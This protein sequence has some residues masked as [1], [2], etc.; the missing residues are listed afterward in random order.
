D[1]LGDFDVQQ[2]AG[3]HDDAIMRNTMGLRHSL[4]ILVETAVTTNPTNSDEAL[5]PTGPA[6]N[7]RRVASHVTV[8]GCSLE[9]MR[10]R[11][12]EVMNVTGMAPLRKQ[13]EGL[14]QNV[15][16]YFSGQ[17]EGAAPLGG[18][19][20]V[21]SIYPPPCAYLLTP[22]QAAEA[23]TAMDLHGIAYVQQEDGSIR[24]P[25]GQSAEPIIPL[26]LDERA[27][28]DLVQGEAFSAPPFDP[29]C[30]RVPGAATKG[31]KAK[32]TAA[33]LIVITGVTALVMRRRL[34]AAPLPG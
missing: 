8:L 28:R 32:G 34:R 19:P 15:P 22:E 17:D 11:G 29:A 16:V 6:T 5:D 9:F 30:G 13:G 21:E 10:E 3:D 7:R 12:A 4:G 31:K 23:K 24:V 1:K 20:D 25:L 27:S 14:A 18:V 26:L 2:T 33:A